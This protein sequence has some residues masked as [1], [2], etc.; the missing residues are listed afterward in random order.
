MPGLDTG[1]AAERVAG[2][3]GGGAITFGGGPLPGGGDTPVRLAPHAW[4]VTVPIGFTNP[5]RR[6]LYG[7]L[8][9]A[10][11]YGDKQGV[12]ARI[13]RTRVSC[14]P[15]V[16]ILSAFVIDGIGKSPSIVEILPQPH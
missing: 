6:H 8:I 5:H 16:G 11:L 3:L 14:L 9:Y 4:Q 2:A 12:A 10:S 7:A 1:T 13:A 15:H